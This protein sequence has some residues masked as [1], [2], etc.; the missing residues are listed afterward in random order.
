MIKNGE[1]D[2]IPNRALCLRASFSGFIVVADG[3]EKRWS[4]LFAYGDVVM[5]T[6]CC[7][8]AGCVNGDTW[9]LSGKSNI[10]MEAMAHLVRRFDI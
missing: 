9:I 10:A 1:V 3:N 6:M 5:M 2:D 4:S 8:I 7:W